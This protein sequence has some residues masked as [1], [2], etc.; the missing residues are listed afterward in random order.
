MTTAESPPQVRGVKLPFYIAGEEVWING[1]RLTDPQWS[2]NLSRNISKPYYIANGPEGFATKTYHRGNSSWQTIGDCWTTY[3]TAQIAADNACEAADLTRVDVSTMPSDGSYQAPLLNVE[4]LLGNTLSTLAKLPTPPED[5]RGLILRKIGLWVFPD[6]SDED[7]LKEP[8]DVIGYVQQNYD[9]TKHKMAAAAPA[10]I[11]APLPLARR[12]SIEG[13][14]TC[15]ESGGGLGHQ[16]GER[17]G[18]LPGGE[19]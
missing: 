10:P 4:A 7:F 19:S 3:H 1:G 14:Y 9:Q 17:A 8:R 13:S 5:I 11:P 15:Q 6:V 18:I 2:H 16:R 12:Y